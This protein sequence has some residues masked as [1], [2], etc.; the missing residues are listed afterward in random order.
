MSQLNKNYASSYAHNRYLAHMKGSL[1][2]R[3]RYCECDP[4]RVVHHTVYPVWFEMGRTEL[5]RSTGK[6]Y[7]EM[8]EAGAFLAVVRLQVSYKK[9]AKYDDE[10]RLETTMTDVG[11]VKI[12]HTYELF[13]GD[14]LLCS[15]STT[16]A[17]I[18]REGKVRQIPENLFNV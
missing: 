11:Q 13:R 15:A 5:L 14:E 16:L 17:C 1:T 9:P 12:E 4:M 18:D 7:R 10:V 3:V 2:V 8:E 6:T